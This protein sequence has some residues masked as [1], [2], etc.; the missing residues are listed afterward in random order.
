MEKMIVRIQKA[1]IT[2]FQNVKHG[3]FRFACNFRND[4]FEETSDLL[5]IYGQ[6]GSG[7]TTFIH[8]LSV[9]DALLAGKVLPKE[10]I[11]HITKDQK[12]AKFSYEF[13]L[14][15][16]INFYK[17]IYEF[18]ICKREKDT[19]DEETE[20]Y[21]PVYVSYEKIRYAN[22]EN[23]KWSNFR[24]LIDCSLIDEKVFQPNIRLQ[25][26]TG[27]NS[28]IVEE[29]RVCKKIAIK[30]STSFIFSR[31]TQKQ[32]LQCKVPTYVKILQSLNYFGRFDLFVIQNRD[33]EALNAA[34]PV[35][36][37][38]NDNS[39][40][41]L[42]L[43]SIAIRFDGP[44]V[45]PE[46]S[47]CRAS[48]VVVVMNTVL[49][50]IVPGLQVE[51]F[52]MGKQMMQDGMEGIRVEMASVRKGHKI[53]IR[54][55]SE[56]IK[57]IISILHMIIAMHNNPSMTLAIDELD[58]GIFEYLLGEILKVVKES[59][60]GQLIFTSHNL[61]P[62]EMLHKN[63]ILFTTT[64]PENR[65]IRLTNVNTNNNLRDLYLHD[66]ILGGQKE[67]IYESTNIFAIGRA[68]RMAGKK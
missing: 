56:G 20:N 21:N 39:I 52:N 34:I 3:A 17:V 24:T 15:D 4:I 36:M 18:I 66:I 1:E 42:S 23:G 25:E 14:T 13:S 53:P 54:Y 12:H 44:T 33:A 41:A 19:W 26:F 10:T 31:E 55:E 5:G 9:L 50:E 57:K 2:N 35:S 67:C 6:N 37:M 32:I 29:L 27:K 40:S 58:A 43:G 64:N 7:K 65:Y 11:N 28:K 49:C 48:E 8:A 45:I 62:L 63:S 30:Q 38:E 51:L 16:S 59:G 60:K 46:K 68:L 61:R 47:Y 22:F